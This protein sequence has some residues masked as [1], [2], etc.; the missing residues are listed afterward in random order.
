MNSNDVSE[1]I[2]LNAI[3]QMASDTAFAACQDTIDILQGENNTVLASMAAN[4]RLN[5]ATNWS[6]HL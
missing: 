2:I 6:E 5:I 4:E 1:P 3:N